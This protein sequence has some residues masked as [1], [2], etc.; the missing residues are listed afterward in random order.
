MNETEQYPPRS[1]VADLHSRQINVVFTNS[2]Q[3]IVALMGRPGGGGC[4]ASLTPT[5][6]RMSL[7]WESREARK[8]SAFEERPFLTEA[9]AGLLRLPAGP[10]PAAPPLPFLCLL[11]DA[12][13][14]P[15]DPRP[16][17][18]FSRGLRNGKG[19]SRASSDSL[20]ESEPRIRS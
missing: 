18:A 14:A 20:D 9:G 19:S 17:D 4:G 6:T 12:D 13:E 10:A 3:K 15:P 2:Q 11:F 16:R 7:S 1:E 5:S 8:A